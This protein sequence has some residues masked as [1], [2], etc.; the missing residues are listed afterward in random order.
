MEG[1]RPRLAL[2]LLP[3]ALLV[4]L[5]LPWLPAAAAKGSRECYSPDG[6]A[7]DWLYACYP[8]RA[9]SHCCADGDFCLDNGACLDAQG[10]NDFTL[11]GCTDNEWGKGCGN[12]CEGESGGG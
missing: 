9:T 7:R 4:V 12:Y 5:L 3:L 6:T 1:L 2:P 8:D 11:Q 10:D